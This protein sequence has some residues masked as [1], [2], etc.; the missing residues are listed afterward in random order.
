M[1]GHFLSHTRQNLCLSEMQQW[2]PVPINAR[3]N[4]VC[5]DFNLQLLLDGTITHRLMF[6]NTSFMKKLRME[7]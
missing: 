2:E 4:I 1:L 3:Y 6:S 5:R 7:T